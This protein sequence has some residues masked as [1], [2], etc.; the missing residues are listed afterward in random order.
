[1][2]NTMPTMGSD[3]FAYSN[4]YSSDYKGLCGLTF[5]LSYLPVIPATIVA[6]IKLAHWS[7]PRS[8]GVRR[9]VI[10]TNTLLSQ[11]PDW[12]FFQEHDFFDD[13]ELN[14]TTGRLTLK[15]CNKYCLCSL[16]MH[17]SYEYTMAKVRPYRF[18]DDPWES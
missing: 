15:M 13:V 18:I 16:A 7:H 12:T 14:Y 9:T 6:C 2:S 11:R 4:A 10:N 3:E 17:I 1:M 8:D 5:Y